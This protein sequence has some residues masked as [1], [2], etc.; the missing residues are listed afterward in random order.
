[1]AVKEL[2]SWRYDWS[3]RISQ[4]SSG[5]VDCFAAVTVASL[6]TRLLWIDVF[7]RQARAVESDWYPCCAV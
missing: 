4:L 7:G 2:A 1:M 5:F 6:K 3:V